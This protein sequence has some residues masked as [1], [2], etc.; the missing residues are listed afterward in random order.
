MTSEETLADRERRFSVSILSILRNAL[1]PYT[2]WRGLG[3]NVPPSARVRTLRA[4]DG[5]GVLAVHFDAPPGARTLVHFHGVGVALR[6]VVRFGA[7]IHRRG[8]GALLVEYRG[9]GRTPGQPTEHG[10]YDDALAALD[11]LSAEGVSPDKI[12]LFGIS[13]GAGVAVEMATRGRGARLILATPFTSMPR[14]IQ[15]HVPF[16]R[17]SGAVRERFDNL[18]KAHRVALPTLVIH[19]DADRVVPLEMA[20]TLTD[21]IRGARLLT[22]PRGGHSDLF[23]RTGSAALYDAITAHAISDE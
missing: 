4:C 12:V 6:D 19:G 7:E 20:R 5:S 8:L 15:H 1:A 3:P 16:A 18:H 14:L 21:A 10:M 17:V 11:T 9:Y 2:R 23:R 13:I 22:V